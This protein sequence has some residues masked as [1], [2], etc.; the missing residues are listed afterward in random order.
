M[1]IRLK[2]E[3]ALKAAS[4][5]KLATA[6][7]INGTSFN[8]SANI[9]TANWGT[10]RTLTIGNTGKTVNGSG[11]VSWSLAEIGA[12]SAK[13]TITFK[14]NHNSDWTSASGMSGKTYMG[15]WHGYL[16]SGTKGYLSLGIVGS[17]QLDIH[18]D[19]DMF[20][21]EDKKVYHEGNEPG[22]L[23]PISIGA[24]TNLNNIVDPGM[25]CCSSNST[26][27]GLTNCPVSVAFSLLVEKH[28]GVKQTLTT[29]V[30][31]GIPLT[32][33]RNYYNGTWGQWLGVPMKQTAYWA[34]N[35]V[36]SSCSGLY[37]FGVGVDQFDRTFFKGVVSRSV[38]ITE[39]MVLFYISATQ[40][41]DSVRYIPCNYYNGS[42]QHVGV[43]YLSVTVNGTVTAT[44][45]PSSARCILLEGMSYTRSTS[46]GN[47]PVSP[48]GL[49]A[50]AVQ[51]KM[52][53]SFFE[54]RD[55]LKM[56]FELDE[57]N[58]FAENS[59]F[60]HKDEKVPEGWTDTPLPL[61][62]IQIELVD[63][64]WVEHGDLSTLEISEPD[65]ETI[66]N[67]KT[68]MEILEEKN[69]QL[70]AEVQELKEMVLKIA[71]N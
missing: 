20:V 22:K 39:G 23:N 67:A 19:G 69:S 9:T 31:T 42:Y 66:I 50:E 16:T 37:G 71:A 5:T 12:A 41:P 65:I 43:G 62:H 53:P 29:Y 32:Y 60:I 36:G 68:P 55:N 45:V 17:E 28:A 52:S 8:G 24:N 56:I 57:N 7:T 4:A 70:E 48:V 44:K 25:Y 64:E 38:D 47:Q 27:S 58:M 3:A 61:Q 49:D 6:H 26:A 15:G 18:L 35:S 11:N 59:K 14:S 63:G 10:G 13:N 46:I 21:K 1:S 2:D 54:D 30:Q 33:I 51:N 34:T 40:L